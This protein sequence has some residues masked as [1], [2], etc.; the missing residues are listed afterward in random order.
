MRS[1]EQ[2]IFP[3]I[4]RGRGSKQP[5]PWKNTSGRVVLSAY[6][7]SRSKR[8]MWLTQGRVCRCGRPIDSPAEAHRHHLKKRGLGGGFR[9]DRFT[10]VICIPCHLREEGQLEGDSNGYDQEDY[11]ADCGAREIS[12]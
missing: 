2:F 11:A 1:P 12:A 5:L 3:R 8:E 6:S 9:D 4:R 10:E 7:Y